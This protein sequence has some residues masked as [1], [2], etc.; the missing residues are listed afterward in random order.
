METVLDMGN[1]QIKISGEPEN[2]YF[3]LR[4]LRIFSLLE[5]SEEDLEGVTVEEI[6]L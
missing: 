5:L 6:N 4:K 2:V 3:V 1:Y